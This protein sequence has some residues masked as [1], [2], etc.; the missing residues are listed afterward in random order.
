[1][2]TI[3]I[4]LPRKSRHQFLC[5]LIQSPVGTTHCSPA[6][7]RW[8]SIRELEK[9]RA[10]ATLLQGHNP[11]RWRSKYQHAH[12]TLAESTLTQTV[13]VTLAES[14]LPFLLNLKSFV[15][16]TCRKQPRRGT[17][18]VPQRCD[19]HSRSPLRLLALSGRERH[20]QSGAPRRS[21]SY[22]GG[23]MRSSRK[24]PRMCPCRQKG[25]AGYQENN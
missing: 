24:S 7:K 19:L 22:P 3:L 21:Q 11:F 18:Q 10:G 5:V 8:E 20:T 2:R 25:G 16:N 15:M 14:A 6:W 4:P 17:R 13:P 1:M 23:L 9:P 12:L